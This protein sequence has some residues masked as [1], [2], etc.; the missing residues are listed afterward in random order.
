MAKRSD[1][2]MYDFRPDPKRYEKKP[3]SYVVGRVKD[4]G[5]PLSRTGVARTMGASDISTLAQDV[6][7]QQ[8]VQTDSIEYM[9]KLFQGKHDLGIPADKRFVSFDAKSAKPAD[10]IFRVMGMLGTPFK[11][12]F[13]PPDGGKDDRDAQDRIEAHLNALYPFMF[14][15]YGV[16]FD[17]QSLW[18]QLVGGSSWIQQTYLPYYWDKTWM[19]PRKD[20]ADGDYNARLA[21]YRGYMGPPVHVQSFDPRVVFP[22]ETPMGVEAHV[23]AYRVQRYEMDAAFAR[24]GKKVTLDRQGRVTDVEQLKRPGQIFPSD[25]GSPSLETAGD[26]TEYFEYIDDVM[27]YYV[28]GDKVV[29]TYAHKGGIQIFPAYGLQTGMAEKAMKSVGI[30]YAVRNEIPQLD[31]ARTMWLQA[32]YLTVMPQLWVQL[33]EGEDPLRDADNNPEQWKLEPGT[34]KQIRG[35]LVNAMKEFGSGMDFRAFVEMLA[36][37]IDLAT[38]TPLARGIAGAQQ[39]GYS[40]NQLSQAMRLMWKPIIESIELQRS[41]M[42][43]HYLR[44]VR[45]GGAIGQQSSIFGLTDQADDGRRTG[46]YYTVN[47]DDIP[48]FF[49]VLAIVN[50]ELPIDQQGNM[51]AYAK[52]A[53]EGYATFEEF[54]REGMGKTNPVTREK[55]IFR[56]MGRRMMFPKA[57]EDAVALGRVRLTSEILKAQGLD[58]LNSVFSMDVQQLKSAGSAG[59]GEGGASQGG[60]QIQPPAGTPGDMAG[61]AGPA[62]VPGTAGLRGGGSIAPTT[63]ANPNDPRPG[64]RGGDMS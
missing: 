33:G 2:A 6:K 25:V 41:M 18:W 50:P 40:I 32:A 26:S 1:A 11:F 9:V 63:G 14:Q 17:L 52:L 13:I 21:G 31:F 16:R 15:K 45:P 55:Q 58:R 51:M 37:D 4:S 35:T 5:A 48:E 62:V 20:E 42:G 28:V 10:I 19:K 47:P 49:R 38:L 30:L 34:V 53:Q 54:T 56:D 29:H 24:V 36:G 3:D 39:P 43:E 64:P 46:K 57:A 44:M 59:G 22:I 8:Q 27:C 60:G 7:A 12:Q 61:G 23:K